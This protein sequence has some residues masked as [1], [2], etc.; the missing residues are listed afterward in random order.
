MNIFHD[1]AASTNSK[2]IR[3]IILELFPNINIQILV[4]ILSKEGENN[5]SHGIGDDEK[6]GIDSL[7]NSFL[8]KPDRTRAISLSSA[9]LDIHQKS[10]YKPFLSEL[11]RLEMNTIDHLPK[12]RD[13][14]LHSCFVYCLGV[15]LFN[16]FTKFRDKI[17]SDLEN[18][19]KSGKLTSY[20]AGISKGEFSF[21]WRLISLLHDIAYPFQIYPADTKNFKLS[22]FLEFANA[23]FSK[24][25]RYGTHP[26]ALVLNSSNYLNELN[27]LTFSRMKA[28]DLIYSRAAIIPFDLVQYS[29][30]LWRFKGWIDHGILSALLVLKIADS[31]YNYHNSAGRI[32]EL[33]VSW[34]RHFLEESIA[35]SA[36]AISYHNIDHESSQLNINQ[37]NDLIQLNSIDLFVG[38]LR[39]SDILQDW[40]RPL[41]D[42]SLKD[43]YIK[44]NEVKLLVN[45]NTNTLTVMFLK[46]SKMHKD[47]VEKQLGALGN[48]PINVIIK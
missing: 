45:D 9:L 14:V 35:H 3:S 48:F 40:G 25:P 33:G 21:R 7:T 42:N 36:L 18:E 23:I 10:V 46:S 26:P 24:L 2:I 4:N 19:T 32:E 8:T 41:S 15:Y 39:I 20:S 5:F 31:L 38:L 11:S 17:I 12:H 22:E 43:K 27:T 16:S 47:K 29:D 44:E 30:D 1:I 6:S 34:E 28:T 13:H 37:K